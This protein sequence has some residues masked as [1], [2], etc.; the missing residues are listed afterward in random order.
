MNTYFSLIRLNTVELHIILTRRV[1]I[2]PVEILRGEGEE[3]LF[4]KI[5]T[6]LS[7][8][9]NFKSL[10]GVFIKIDMLMQ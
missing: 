3:E 6:T 8:R 10:L 2:L 7:F 9:F 1:L 4:L 5:M